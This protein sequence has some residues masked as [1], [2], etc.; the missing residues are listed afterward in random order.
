MGLPNIEG[1]FRRYQDALID[2]YKE[3][4]LLAATDGLIGI[5]LEALGA[6]RLARAAELARDAAGL[7]NGRKFATYVGGYKD[8]EVVVGMSSKVRRMCGEDGVVEQL[9]QDASF[10]KAYGWRRDPATGLLEWAEIPVCYSCQ[11][12]YKPFQFPSDVKAEPGGAWGW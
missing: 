2:I 1:E 7:Q 3:A 11:A 6:L 10:T 4:A 12:K 8:G 5:G 9:G